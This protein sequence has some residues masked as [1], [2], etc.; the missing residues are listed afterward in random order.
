[1]K[2]IILMLGA[3]MIGVVQA[4]TVA[5]WPMTKSDDGSKG[6]MRCIESSGNDL[7]VGRSANV[8]FDANDL[9]WNLP[10]NPYPHVSDAAA[11]AGGFLVTDMLTSAARSSVVL[12][13]ANA[14]LAKE[15]AP[16]HD[17]TIEGWARLTDLPAIGSSCVMLDASFYNS[18]ESATF[19][20]GGWRL[21]LSH[22][23][24]QTITMKADVVAANN[25]SRTQVSLANELTPASLTNGWHHYAVVFK[26]NAAQSK[27]V[28]KFYLDGEV[29]DEGETSGSWY[30]S[31]NTISYEAPKFGLVGGFRQ[32]WSPIG[33]FACWRVSDEALEPEQFLCYGGAGTTVPTGKTLNYWK[34]S[35]TA[36][37]VD[38]RDFVGTANLSEAS[39]SAEAVTDDNPTVAN[40]DATIGFTGDS[41][42]NSGSFQSGTSYQTN[43][44]FLY[45]T[46][47]TYLEDVLRSKDGWTMEGYFKINGNFGRQYGGI[48]SLCSNSSS[49][50]GNGVNFALRCY[51]NSDS[52][53]RCGLVDAAVFSTPQISVTD[54]SFS[55]YLTKGEWTH[56]ALSLSYGMLT[57]VE[58]VIYKFYINGDMKSSLTNVYVQTYNKDTKCITF[59]GT[60][61]AAES[62]ARS[63]AGQLS[64]FR[65]SKGALEPSE[66]LCAT[67]P[68]QS[69]SDLAYWPLDNAS[70]TADGAVAKGYEGYAMDK[71]SGT[72]DGS[73]ERV[74]SRIPAEKGVP[75]G[76]V[77][78]VAIGT[79]GSF[80]AAHLGGDLNFG[81]SWSV[82][83]Y[84]KFNA[85]TTVDV[86]GTYDA[87][88]GKGW[89][90]VLDRS[91]ETPAFRLYAAA[92]GAPFI[93]AAF[94]GTGALG[95]NGWNHLLLT[96]DKN[97][98]WNLKVNR[99]D[100][101]TLSSTPH[102]T[103]A[104]AGV[105]DFY[106]GSGVY[107]IWRATTGILPLADSLYFPPNGFS[108]IVR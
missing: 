70:G 55:G 38:G 16:D 14:N 73:S 12:T 83:G 21:L 69:P 8:T 66:F 81:A 29:Q 32:N 93:D 98:T 31:P 53:L 85:D 49:I 78:S 47:Q 104:T 96:H 18:I 106:I 37:G 22:P 35:G 1:M 28:W 7:Y 103:G 24:D 99:V 51:G 26:E 74:R 76:N 40:P 20:A 11:A 13:N 67:S 4:K 64:S 36:G 54:E 105:T 82:E 61:G 62:N 97:G 79:G 60:Y 77:G 52:E 15:L 56:F 10:P 59:G 89:K 6:V 100:A 80:T 68:T 94:A 58:Q 19:Q 2:Q 63:F 17:F 92:G 34:L 45:L 71:A 39:N 27:G 9:G 108:I 91:G 5:Y 33:D 75:E 101:G 23:D 25:T 42:E 3:C 44:K 46:D 57:N 43:N 72:V 90:L 88:S 50:E 102:G 48:F 107:D 65:L 84:L 86:C 30:Y 95:E 41:G 87:V